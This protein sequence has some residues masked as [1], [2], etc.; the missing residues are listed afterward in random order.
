MRL[1][2][3]RS[4]ALLSVAAALVT[5]ALKFGAFTLTG[6]VGL[7]SDALESVVNLV[8]ALVAVW[9]LTLAARPADEEHTYGHSKAEYFS[10][11]VEGALI[12]LA[13]ALIVQQAVPR[14]LHPQPIEQVGLGLLIAGVGAAING[15]VGLVLWRAGG[16]LRSITLQ[17]DARHLFTDVWT[18]GGVLVGVGLVA[19]TGWL[20]LD[21]LIALLV[22]ANILWTGWK[23]LHESG[24]GLL[25]TALPAAD[26]RALAH[27]LDG[28]R[29]RGIAFHALRTRQAAARRF[30]SLHVLVPGAW[31]VQ[32]GHDLAEQVEFALRQA[33]PDTTVFT[34]LEPR[35]DPAAYDDTGLDR[36]TQASASASASDAAPG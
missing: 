13:A 9:A 19:L 23:L 34:H 5:M 27:V 29:A 25:D 22:A 11:G 4:Y 20:F 8:A 24:L 2:S 3:R 10:S 12:A 16:R 1:H 26:Q 36:R 33:L 18:T 30:V 28:F 35:E 15:G 31:T 6:S 14:L 21:P 32:Q 17:A 7:L